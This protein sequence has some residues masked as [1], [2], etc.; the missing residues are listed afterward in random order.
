MT[1]PFIPVV[2]AGG[3]GSRL[4]PL[5]R[6]LYPKQ[7][8]SLVGE[9]T[10]LQA[11]L[12]RL[13]GLEGCAPPMLVAGDEHRFLAAEQVRRRPNAPQSIVLEP[14]GR[15][16]APAVAVAAL[17]ARA[18]GAD[19]LLLVL[20]ADHVIGD[21]PA[22][23]GAVETALAQAETGSL[24]TFGIR[25]DHPETGYGYIH[26]GAP[27]DVPGAFRVERFVEKPD[28]PTAQRFVAAGDYFWNSGM[29]AFRASVYLEELKAHAP[30]ILT[31]A[32]AAVAGAT[33]DLDFT[34]LAAGPFGAC[35]SES[36]DYAVMERTA[37]AV[38]VPV[39]MA[40]NDLG[41]WRAVWETSG[42]DAQG[43]VLMGDVIA[44]DVSGSYIRAEERLVAAV[45][46]K[47][48]VVIETGDGVLVAPRERSQDVKTLV[49]RLQGAGRRELSVHR[50]VYRPWGTYT[51][52]EV[53]TRF[54]VKHITVKPGAA[55]SLQMH[56]HR[57]EHWVIVSGTAR[58]TRNDEVFLLSENQSTYI[59]IGTRHR[60][61]NP[62]TIPL[63]MVEVQ[64]GAYLGEDDIVRFDDIYGRQGDTPT[65]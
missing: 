30:D 64:S 24:V 8:I 27:A 28:L 41:S 4:W 33:R 53:A 49:K 32:E 40:W 54:Q 35:P 26:Q 5:S 61:E 51:V 7:L 29:F 17:L 16:T 48:L 34:R 57:A 6:E 2:L 39:S 65:K 45:G 58:I 3:I 46:I 19:P 14:E 31:A 38:V 23:H 22:F 42:P 44:E 63:E 21:V 55:L 56:H 47:D 9:Q 12:G 59:P 50:T 15:N 52:L 11:T 18:G 1:R 43:N 60:L 37:R 36:I 13:E 62:G 20:P 10:M 25:P